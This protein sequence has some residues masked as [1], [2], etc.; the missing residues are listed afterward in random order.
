[1]DKLSNELLALIVDQLELQGRIGAYAAISPAWQSN[2]EKRTFARIRLQST[3]LAQ[4]SD[5]FSRCPPRRVLMRELDFSVVLH[6]PGRK[7]PERI[8]NQIMFR[9][10]V[11]S[12]LAVLKQWD[13]E[14][15]AAGN[16]PVSLYLILQPSPVVLD[17]TACSTDLP[18]PD[19]LKSD[20][21]LAHRYLALSPESNLNLYSPIRRV[22]RYL[23]YD[24]EPC[25]IHPATMCQ[26]AGLF[27]RLEQLELKWWDPDLRYSTNL[28][29]ED[30]VDQLCAAIRRLAQPTVVSLTL[31]NFLIS[32]D[33]FED[34]INNCPTDTSDT[35]HALESL[36]ISGSPVAPNGH[37]Y[38][39]GDPLR[40]SPDYEAS[41]P[42]SDSDNEIDT[43]S[44]ASDECDN[45]HDKYRQEN[46]R[47]PFHQ[48]RLQVDSD[49]MDPLLH[50]YTDA[51]LH[52]GCDSKGHPTKPDKRWW[53]IFVYAVGQWLVPGSLFEKWEEWAGEKG[54]VHM[55]ICDASDSW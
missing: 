41:S 17:A 29:D 36:W 10:A 32:S 27:T 55:R 49:T 16:M 13:D 15:E 20:P 45:Q 4:F 5:I 23:V 30:G 14:E 39:T 24:G 12:L 50:S 21:W 43:E 40:Y 9:A 47:L 2:I 22:K 52:L 34:R 28:T 11:T 38:F 6:E 48:W 7:R 37:W 54:M 18:V 35:W 53:D 44:E 33:L 51:I 31:E 8:R 19:E 3:S 26:T 46:G 1:M 42:I 25:H